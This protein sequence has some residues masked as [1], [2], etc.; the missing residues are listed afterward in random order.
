MQEIII[1][2]GFKRFHLT[3][4]LIHK[5]EVC[6]RYKITPVANPEKNLILEN[7]RPLIRGRYKLKKRKIDW[8]VIE[9]P[10]MGPKTVQ[11]IISAIESPLPIVKNFDPAGS[12]LFGRT[13][14]ERK[15]GKEGPPLRERP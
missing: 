5:D 11:Q 7:N 12:R 8:K 4:Q 6:E 3:W 14:P 1:Q 2:Q 10:N 9:G 13:K 15:K